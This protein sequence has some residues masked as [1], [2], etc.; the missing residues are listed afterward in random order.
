I[1]AENRDVISNDEV[2]FLLQNEDFLTKCCHIHSVWGPIKECINILESNTATLADC[3][4]YM[5]KLAVAIFKLPDSNQFK[6][7]AIHIFNNRYIEF[8]HPA[9]LLCYYIHPLYREA[10][11][12]AVKLWKNL[13]HSEQF[14]AKLSPYDLPYV[15]EM[16]TPELWW[17]D[18]RTRLAI[19][20]LENI[21]KIR[22]YY[23]TNIKAELLYYD[24]TST[25][26]ELRNVANDSSVGALMSL[27]SE[28]DYLNNV[29]LNDNSIQTRNTLIIDDII[30]FNFFNNNNEVNENETNL[31]NS[32]NLDYDPEL[33]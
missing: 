3:F 17:G 10:A 27:E 12:V 28:N 32:Y 31:D 1:I 7:S 26:N 24:K 19:Q 22:S 30:D 29:N 9:Y 4:I 11:L 23:L 2:L 6:T 20:R 25:S 21:S 8:Q 5:I 13:N 18:C 33:L 16:D 14:E 15:E